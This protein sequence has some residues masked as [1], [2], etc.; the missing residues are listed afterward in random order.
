MK[1]SNWRPTGPGLCTLI[2]TIAMLGAMPISVRAQF[3]YVSLPHSNTVGEYSAAGAATNVKLITTGLDRPIWVAVSGNTLFVANTASGTIGA[4]NATTGDPINATFI[5][6]VSGGLAVS[7]NTLFV[8]GGGTS[9][10]AGKIGEYDA[11]TGT[12]INANLITGLT[13]P[14]T[15]AVS[16]NTLF[17]TRKGSGP[18]GSILPCIVSAYNATT[19][20]VIKA[21]FITG[22]RNPQGLAVSGNNLFVA[23]SDRDA[24]SEYDAKTGAVINA[25][26]I[27]G[28]RA[29]G[30]VQFKVPVGIAVSGNDLFVT[31]NV[32]NG[33][34]GKYN[35][36]TGAS[37]D[38]DFISGLNGPTG[39]AVGSG[40]CG[41]WPL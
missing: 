5:T 2:L 22:L 17:V 19:G 29:D 7:G 11:S 37:I 4:Y 15:V 3:I 8:V 34:V 36:T 35:A 13:E 14:R 33:M 31:N 9:A 28:V 23:D 6:G 18:P 26:F 30:V 1:T 40:D 21:D 16:G 39:L 41:C 25:N 24:I 10:G 32:A 38:A 27:V 20:E 12:V